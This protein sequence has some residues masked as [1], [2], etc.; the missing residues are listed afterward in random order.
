MAVQ[1]HSAASRSANPSSNAQHLLEGGDPSE[2]LT[3]P[4]RSAQTPS[5]NVSF[6]QDD[7]GGADFGLHAPQAVETVE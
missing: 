6:G 2:M 1:R 5:F 4:R 7:G 3:S